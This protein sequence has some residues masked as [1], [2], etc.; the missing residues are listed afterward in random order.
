MF[1]TFPFFKQ[2]DAM[3]CGPTCL[4]MIAAHFG[5]RYP[6][7][8]L[9]QHCFLSREG[10]SAAGITEGADS[11]GLNT[12]TIKIK[13]D[14]PKTIEE[15]CLLNAPLPCIAHWNQNHFVVIYKVTRRA[16][17]VADPGQGKFKLKRADFERSW[18]DRKSVV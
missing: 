11:I 14:N 13:Y 10:V 8:Y 12:M 6:L 4:M 3:D 1:K 2:R 5:K 17:W 16:V 18:A 9:R 15:G 7:P